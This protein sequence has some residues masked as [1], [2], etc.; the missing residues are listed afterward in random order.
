MGIFG[1]R[2]L[3]IVTFWM[4][5]MGFFIFQSRQSA[6]DRGRRHDDAEGGG[7]Y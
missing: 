3:I 6:R 4:I 1:V 2:W 5:G 7:V